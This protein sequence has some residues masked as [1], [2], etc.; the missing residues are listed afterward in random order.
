MNA[1]EAQK[2]FLLLLASLAILCVVVQSSLPLLIKRNLEHTLN[3]IL[4][5]T[6][7]SRFIRGL[8]YLING[9]KTV[10]DGYSKAG[11]KPFLIATPTNNHLLVSSPTHIEEL[12]TAPSIQLSLHAVAKEMLQP[13]YTM[14]GFEW[15]DQRGVEG[16]GFVRALRSLLTAHLPQLLPKLQLII[17]KG[18]RDEVAQ[19]RRKDSGLNIA[20][21]DFADDQK[22]YCE[23]QNTPFLE[24]ALRFPQDVI[25]AAELVRL[26]PNFLAPFVARL[27][28]Q[29][30]K[31]SKVMFDCLVP[32]V[33]QRL[34]CRSLNHKN[35]EKAPTS[36]FSLVD[37]CVFPEYFAPLREELEQN[38]LPVEGST[39][40]MDSFLKESMRYNS[41][42]A[43]TCRRKALDT[44]TFSGGYTVKVGDWACVPQ[45]AMMHDPQ[46][47]ENPAAFDGFRFLPKDGE[48]SGAKDMAQ[49]ENPNMFTTSSPNWLIWGSGKTVCPGRFYGAAIMRLIMAEV[50]QSYDCSLR[51][52][53]LPRTMTWRS[54]IV[55]RE[56]VIMLF[57]K[58]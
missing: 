26:M 30:H 17:R 52:P 40:R 24:A 35:S 46:Y 47:Y 44:F 20:R 18:L 27:A 6:P 54:S 21:S 51:D 29:N 42:D 31:S 32:I 48:K 9:P 3:H 5:Y 2:T 1:L 4:Q 8:R 41:I 25:I 50:L 37:L 7:G 58:R 23:A 34:K 10:Q 45:Q 55:P 28:T 22:A 38:P 19:Y 56:G 36:T 16:T 57:Q 13:K 49:N 53:K 12:V 43:I 14:R 33:E 11:G 39:P 15:Q